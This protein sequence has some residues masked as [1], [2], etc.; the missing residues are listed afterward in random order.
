MRAPCAQSYRVQVADRK[1]RLPSSQ[2]WSCESGASTLVG[3][4][5]PCDLKGDMASPSL[6]LSVQQ[7]DVM[8]G[9]AM[10]LIAQH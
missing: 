6:S 5:G 8:I 3:V 7:T 1:S 9:E 2:A 4:K 10:R